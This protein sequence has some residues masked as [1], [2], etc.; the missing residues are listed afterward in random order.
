[1]LRKKS[2]KKL[3]AVGPAKLQRDS[4]HPLQLRWPAKF[5]KLLGRMPD[6]ALAKKMGVSLDAVGERLQVDGVN[7]FEASFGK[8]LEQTA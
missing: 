8:L 2:R 6:T 7:S 4:R 1:M 5:L 3:N